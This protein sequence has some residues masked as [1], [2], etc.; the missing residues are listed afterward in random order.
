M[1]GEG[2]LFRVK[3]SVFWIVEV[4]EHGE[5]EAWVC[6]NEAGAIDELLS[7]IDVAKLDPDTLDPEEFA[8][9]YNVQRVEIAEDKYNM[10][11][12]S[13]LKI[14]MKGMTKK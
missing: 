9:T 13:L 4:R 12:V 10:T 7:H 6:D 3:D 14:F 2:K 1:A 5:T 11:G 8:R